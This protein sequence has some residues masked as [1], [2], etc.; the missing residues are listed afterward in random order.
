MPC[1]RTSLVNKK[2][3][4]INMTVPITV[5]KAPISNDVHPK[6]PFSYDV[7]IQSGVISAPQSVTNVHPTCVAMAARTLAYVASSVLKMSRRRATSPIGV[8]EVHWAP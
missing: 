1:L 7:A 4:N 2:T 3:W 8:P 5:P 6:P